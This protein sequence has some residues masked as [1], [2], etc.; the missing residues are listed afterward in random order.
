MGVSKFPYEAAGSTHVYS[1]GDTAH[2]YTELKSISVTHYP[3][4]HE[5]STNFMVYGWYYPSLYF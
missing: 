2:G 3:F 4:S 5:T 1:I